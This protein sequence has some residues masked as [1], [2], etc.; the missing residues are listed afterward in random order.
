MEVKENNGKMSR[1]FPFRESGHGSVGAPSFENPFSFH[2]CIHT[3]GT[4]TGLLQKTQ[5]WG[6]LDGNVAR[7]DR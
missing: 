2:L 1:G 3:D 5:G 7:K 6:T 4:F